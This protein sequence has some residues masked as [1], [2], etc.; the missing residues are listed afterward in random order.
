MR[1]LVWPGGESEHL[2]IVCSVAKDVCE[3]M[4]HQNHRQASS[5]M[6]S[7]RMC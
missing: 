4:D 6:W 7:L 3:A 2:P 5:A 1:T